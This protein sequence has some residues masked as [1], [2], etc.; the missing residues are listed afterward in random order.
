MSQV[1]WMQGQNAFYGSRSGAS[2]ATGSRRSYEQGPG[3][4][5]PTAF[6]GQQVD[7]GAGVM[8]LQAEM[9]ERSIS[10]DFARI[11]SM[12]PGVY[13]SP[14]PV[15]P[16]PAPT[17]PG[18]E[19][20]PSLP[21]YTPSSDATRTDIGIEEAQVP[22]QVVV[23]STAPKTGVDS[24]WLIAAAVIGVFLALRK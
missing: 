5:D 24:K 21:T 14:S 6:Y 8:P 10:A 20:Q 1:D 19:A 22:M 15:A 4:D 3:L 16:T 23:P 2:S 17:V 9:A 18:P 13:S 11:M 12:Q 7:L